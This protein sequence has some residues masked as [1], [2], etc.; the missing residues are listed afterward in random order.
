M[1]HARVLIHDSRFT[2]HDS[3]AVMAAV[4]TADLVKQLRDRTG[5]GMMECKKALT[6][7][8]GD[9]DAAVTILRKAGLAQA[10]KRAGRT[11]AQGTIGSYLHMGGKIGV[12]VEVN[13][14]SDF[15]ART[16][17]FN[18]LVKE[19]AMHIA[20]ADPKW[21]RREDVP[22]EAVEKEKA[23]YRAQMEKENKPAHVIDKIIEGKLGSFYS[24]FVLVDQ[25]SIRDSAV[26]IGQLVAQASAKTGENIQISRFVRFRV[27]EAAE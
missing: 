6:E 3:R 25:P 13:C 2:I 23:I 8:N 10:A 17:D 16:E 11:T 7:A 12:L 19:V 4:I 14:E 1:T 20:A 15:V 27:G 26:T 22:A 5:A 24:Q 21:V 9:M 18:N